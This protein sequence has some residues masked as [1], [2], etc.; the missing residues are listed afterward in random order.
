MGKANAKAVELSRDFK[1]KAE[2]K[3]NIEKIILFGSQVTGSSRKGSDIDLLVVSDE[4]ENKA[5]FMSRLFEEWHINQKKKSPVDFICFT[6]EEFSKLASK[7]TIVKQAV[8]E[9]VEI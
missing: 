9:G 3:Y 8:E 4:V 6:P 2:S 5:E 7:I 1:E